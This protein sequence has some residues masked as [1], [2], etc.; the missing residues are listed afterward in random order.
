MKM[1]KAAAICIAA[2]VMW[3]ASC[4]D[5]TSSKGNVSG[6]DKSE[7]IV[8]FYNVENIFDTENDPK[9]NDDD[10]TPSGKL[11]WTPD[12]YLV[13]LDRTGEAFQMMDANFPDVIGLCEVENLKVLSDLVATD[14][15]KSQGYK[16]VHM[17]SE[18]E[19]GIDVALIYK[20]TSIE[21]VSSK[22]I[23]VS[24]ADAN[25]RTRDIL[26]VE[27][28]VHGE[29]IHFF[30][31][32]W[33]SRSG[34]QEQSE[35]NRIAAAKTL[36]SEIDVIVKKDANA[37]V[38]CMGDFNDHPNDKSMMEALG[39]NGTVGA[40]M[41]NLMAK[42]HAAGEGSYWYKGSWGALDQFIVSSAWTSMKGWSCTDADA[43]IIKEPKLLF[44]DG[45]GVA[46]PSRTYAGDDYK[47]GYS[48]H[49]PVVVKCSWK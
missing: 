5:T 38:I 36:K 28:V 18:D 21:V 35:P 7:L 26:Y 13:K 37:K 46:R 14:R 41:I 29:K 16:I 24:L 27:G 11:Q 42:K 17:D 45:N 3:S 30:V 6:P 23:K 20:S 47:S 22:K 4:K 32:H 48:D 1:M 43:R 9:T 10:F 40:P 25:D 12:K 8:G 39:A 44:T 15:L 31:N 49:L 19:R 34:G 33:P 2:I